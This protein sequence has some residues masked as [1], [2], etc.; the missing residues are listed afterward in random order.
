MAVMT[1][2]RFREVFFF[3]EG[4]SNVS[5]VNICLVDVYFYCADDFL[6]EKTIILHI[7]EF[8]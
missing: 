6:I 5:F 7:Y 4:R 8:T 1:E 3:G 2:R